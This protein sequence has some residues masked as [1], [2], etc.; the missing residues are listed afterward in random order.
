[1]TGH[2]ASTQHRPKDDMP[3]ELT[4]LRDVRTGNGSRRSRGL[5]GRVRRPPGRRHLSPTVRAASR[6]RAAGPRDCG[7]A[8]AQPE[9]LEAPLIMPQRASAV[10]GQMRQRSSPE[11]PRPFRG[12]VKPRV[13]EAPAKTGPQRTRRNR[14]RSRPKVGRRQRDVHRSGILDVS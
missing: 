12:S 3:S 5:A 8:R 10:R 13:R 1:M 9:P 11:G 2:L 6:R 14:A 4:S 7:A